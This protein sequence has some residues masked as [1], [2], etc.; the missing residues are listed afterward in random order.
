VD[1]LAPTRL[2]E[3]TRDQIDSFFHDVHRRVSDLLKDTSTFVSDLTTYPSVIVGPGATSEIV[4]QVRLIPLGGTVVL[5]VAV[6]DN[7]SVHQE[8]VDIGM[9]PDV[10]TLEA[11]ERLI[12]AAY[13]GRPLDDPLDTR[14]LMSDFPAVVRRVVGP[15]SQ[16]LVAAK[17]HQREVYVGGTAQMANLWDDLTMVQS[18]LELIDRQGS[19][20][21][22]MTDDEE[23]T[24]V[25]FGPDIGD[26]DDLA[27]VTTTYEL[28]TG[29]RGRIGVMGPMRM[30][31]RRTIRVVEQVS[32]KLGDGSGAEQ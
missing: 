5:A 10:E 19:L 1:H 4:T 32:E 7:G 28:P 15:V 21:E 13:E 18:L 24:H 16:Q 22:L 27:V 3:G 30:N 26:V 20:V 8:F 29:G 12:V 9:T 6:A 2:R 17:S 14:L 25:R 31:Y 11:A 23:G